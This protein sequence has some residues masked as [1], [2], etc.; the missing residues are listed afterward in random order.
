MQIAVMVPESVEGTIKS[1][2]S[3]SREVMVMGN[4][5][6][7]WQKTV[8]YASSRVCTTCQKASTPLVGQLELS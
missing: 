1:S 3:A 7:A 8:F 5:K 4:E 6:N 2:Q